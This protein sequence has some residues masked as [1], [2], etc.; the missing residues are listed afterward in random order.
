[1][2]DAGATVTAGGKDAVQDLIVG[3]AKVR[4]DMCVNVSNADRP[5]F[6]YGSGAWGQALFRV[7]VTF[8]DFHISCYSCLPRMFQS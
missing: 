7:D 5:Y 4:P 6:R 8:G 3:L 2:I 1:M